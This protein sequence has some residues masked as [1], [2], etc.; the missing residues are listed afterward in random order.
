MLVE[1]S[2]WSKVKFQNRYFKKIVKFLHILN[3]RDY[4][5]NY[6]L[7]D[8]SNRIDKDAVKLK[9]PPLAAKGQHRS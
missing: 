6:K 2:L 4:M 9:Q 1:R 3:G 8:W 7:R 5:H